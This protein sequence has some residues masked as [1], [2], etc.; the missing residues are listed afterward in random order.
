MYTPHVGR[1][2]SEDP[3]GYVDGPNRYLYVTN[4][5]TGR[6]DPSGLFTNPF[7]PEPQICRICP[8][9]RCKSI[10]V[11]VIGWQ[12][13]RLSYWTIWPFY[14]WVSLL[15]LLFRVSAQTTGGCM[16]KIEQSINAKIRKKL[17]GSSDWETGALSSPEGSCP[18]N[19][20]AERS[21]C[22][23]QCWPDT[24]Q[25]L[26]SYRDA[27][28]GTM[29]G[30]FE[31]NNMVGLRVELEFTVDVCCVDPRGSKLCTTKSCFG[32]A[33]ITRD[34]NGLAQVQGYDSCSAD[35]DLPARD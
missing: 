7:L 16:C 11:D 25:G 15:G 4:G 10:S 3:A 14:R 18:G 1:W 19:F 28:G 30:Y 5:P 9:C 12:T 29:T 31:D 27:P 8:Q 6:S 34:V 22:D 32:H 2:L 35:R 13:L 21:Q 17:P 23:Y 24:C 33:E 20:T 26:I